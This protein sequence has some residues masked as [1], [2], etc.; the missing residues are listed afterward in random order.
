[1]SAS[2]AGA[3]S[4][5]VGRRRTLERD[6][7]DK[8]TSGISANCH[9][10]SQASAESSSKDWEDAGHVQLCK[11]HDRT[12]TCVALLQAANGTLAVSGRTI[13]SCC[14]T[15]NQESKWDSFVS[16]GKTDVNRSGGQSLGRGVLR[17]YAAVGKK[18]T[19]TVSI[20]DIR[21]RSN[22]RQNSNRAQI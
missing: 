20:F 12:V 7:A 21:T 17:C 10:K 14:G 9:T 5:I 1:M 18:R 11:G 13:L 8:L 3:H 22:G 6:V 19:A 16:T 2:R 15:W 4:A